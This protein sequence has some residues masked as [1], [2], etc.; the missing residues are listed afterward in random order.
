MLLV[1]IIFIPLYPWAQKS[2]PVEGSQQSRQSTVASHEPV[3]SAVPTVISFPSLGR[4]LRIT[5]GRVSSKKWKWTFRTFLA[6]SAQPSSVTGWAPHPQ[7]PT[8]CFWFS[9]GTKI[10]YL[11]SGSCK[12]PLTPRHPR[13]TD[14][15]GL[16]SSSEDTLLSSLLAVKRPWI[17]QYSWYKYS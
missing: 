16:Y 11:H 1:S 14:N 3:E 15:L 8:P 13:V 10:C 12:E 4:N 5:A 17:W 6:L 9:Y 2:F 7:P